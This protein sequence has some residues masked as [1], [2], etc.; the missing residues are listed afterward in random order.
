M[1]FPSPMPAAMPPASAAAL[2]H[3]LRQGRQEQQL[4]ALVQISQLAAT[5]AELRTQLVAAGAI[6]VLLRQL[7]NGGLQ[8][9]AAGVLALLAENN[10]GAAAAIA[11]GGCIPKLVG[12]LHK[13]D[14]DSQTAAAQLLK[15]LAE[16]SPER[17]QAITTAGGVLPLLELCRSDGGTL[18]QE[19]A[20]ALANLSE[21]D[22]AVAVMLQAGGVHTLVR[23]LER[24]PADALALEACALALKDNVILWKRRMHVP[25]LWRLGR[26]LSLRSS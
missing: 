12:M 1:V 10:G 25:Q 26:L 4:D 15:Q 8:A 13:S 23:L 11:R 6:P 7:R 3:S 21:E 24:R 17:C 14:P 9:A 19:A 20:K 22:G 18:Q 16:G 2:V 5:S